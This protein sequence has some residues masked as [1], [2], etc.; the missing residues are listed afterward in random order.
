[1]AL[2]GPGQNELARKRDGRGPRLVAVGGLAPPQA[3]RQDAHFPLCRLS[4]RR[5]GE[6]ASS[7][8]IKCIS[9]SGV[10]GVSDK[11]ESKWL[12]VSRVSGVSGV[13]GVSDKFESKWLTV[14]GV[15][16]WAVNYS[17]VDLLL[18]R[19]WRV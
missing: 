14:S 16:A 4:P 10:S 15:S 1:D 6:F 7:I 9:V 12:T 3:A 8:C 11:F 2:C 5:L 17:T 18:R 13:S 19:N